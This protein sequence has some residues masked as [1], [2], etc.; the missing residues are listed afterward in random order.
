MA[1][2]EYTYDGNF[3][4][5]IPIVGQTGCGKTALAQNLE[6]MTYTRVTASI[7]SKRKPTG[8]VKL[9]GPP[10]LGFFQHQYQK[11]VKMFVFISKEVYILTYLQ[12]KFLVIS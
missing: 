6:K 2:A 4:G 9:P 1:S 3:E 11:D 12:I 7:A 10:R 8:G 5:N